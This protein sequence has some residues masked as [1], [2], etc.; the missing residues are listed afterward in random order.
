V[1]I[2]ATDASVND[3]LCADLPNLVTADGRCLILSSAQRDQLGFTGRTRRTLVFGDKRDFAPRFG[4]AWRPLSSDKLV[5]RAGYGIF[6]DLANLNTLEFVS[7]NPVFGPSQLYNTAFGAP[8]PQ[9]GGVTTPIEDVFG[10]GVTPRLSEQYAALWV[11][12]HFV[13]PRV[14]QWSFGGQSQFAQNWSIDVSYVGMKANHLDNFFINQPRPGVGDLQPR[15]PY[16]DFSTMAFFTSDGN[17]NYNALQAKLTKRYSGGLLFL[18][19]YTWAKAMSDSEGNEGSFGPS[20]QW[21]QDNNNRRANYGRAVSDAR[22]RF[23]FSPIWEVP[24]GNRRHFLNRPGVANQILGQWQVSAILTLQ[25]GFPF[26]ILSSQDFSNTGSYSPRPDRI[27]SGVGPK[28]ID[29]WFDTS[30]FTTDALQQALGAGQPSFGNSGRNIL[31]GPG[32]AVLDFALYKDFSL[33]ERLKL[34]FRA[35]A[36]NLLNHPNFGLPSTT[37]GTEN[38]GK[39]GR[40]FEPRDIQFGLKIVF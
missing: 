15:R 40:A 22:H 10:L 11:E 1:L 12:P 29:S 31:D 37:I 20:G 21:S 34:R 39:I 25:S 26:S 7:G 16:P 24:L 30:C 2:T 3:S 13:P 27:C 18:T 32:Q 9:I 5:V 14:Q 33:G 4:L 38:S 17:S 36:F 19:S 35:E 8:P 23:V 28:T 6:Y